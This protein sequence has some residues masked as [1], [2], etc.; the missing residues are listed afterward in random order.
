[1]WP[2]QN[3]R[4][5]RQGSRARQLTAPSRIFQLIETDNMYN[6]QK[7]VMCVQ[8]IVDYYMRFLPLGKARTLNYYMD[9]KPPR[10]VIQ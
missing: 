6:L 3:H 9:W 4:L 8:S 2:N 1:M 7:D 10:N 5:F